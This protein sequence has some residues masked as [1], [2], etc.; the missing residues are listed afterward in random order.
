MHHQLTNEVFWGDRHAP[1]ELAD[2]VRLVVC[3]ADQAD[4][5]DTRFS[6]RT[7][8]IRLAL[9][10][11]ESPGAAYFSQLQHVISMAIDTNAFPLLVHCHAGLH[12][13]PH[14]ALFIASAVAGFAHGVV[15]RLESRMLDLL[16]ELQRMEYGAEVR[17]RLDSIAK[18][19]GY[20]LQM[21][22]FSHTG[23][24]GDI[25]Y[26]LPAIR[27]CGGGILYVWRATDRHC[28][29][30]KEHY[31][32]IRP[33]I[34]QQSYIHDVRWWDT[35]QAKDC[36]LNQFRRNLWPG[37]T[38]AQAQLTAVGKPH[39]EA[40]RAW[41]TVDRAERVAPVIFA[42]GGRWRNPQFPWRRVYEKYGKDAV[43][44][45]T[46]EEWEDFTRAVGPVAYRRTDDLLEAARII[47]GA[48]LIVSNQS[49]LY[50]I[51]E[52]LKKP[53]VVEI[54]LDHDNCRFNRPNV[55]HGESATVELP[56]LITLTG[57]TVNAPHSSS[58]LLPPFPPAPPPARHPDPACHPIPESLHH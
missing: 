37:R 14:A 41:L 3:V 57:P 18:D 19:E 29:M 45:G 55:V 8:Y 12:R 21:G 40:E 52:G 4:A 17:K 32:A 56:D 36:P 31:T 11:H 30:R 51:A 43:F 7:P 47:A 28:R 42:R 27:A 16:P 6:P 26:G 39:S 15:E 9:P 44:L 25:I 23:E 53:A 24:L 46:L 1:A 10:D 54:D 48:D 58:S 2:K 20:L 22:W 13:G 5:L 38:I 35:W 50:A 34:L 33:L 49:C